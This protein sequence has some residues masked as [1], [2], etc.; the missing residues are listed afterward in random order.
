MQ[1]YDVVIVGAGPA[2]LNCAEKLAGSGKTVLVLEQKDVVGPKVCAGG[3]TKKDIDYLKLP[4]KLVGRR[5]GEFSLHTPNQNIAVELGDSFISTVDRK[6]LGQWQLGKILKLGATVKVSSKVTKICK[7]HVVVNNSE[8]IG[9]RHL[10]GADGSASVVRKHIGLEVSDLGMAIQYI[11]PTKKYRKL[12]AF[13]D[14]DIFHSW[15]CW[16]F[17]HRDFVSIGCGGNPRLISPQKLRKN[18]DKWLK[19]NKINVSAGKFEAFPIN[20]DYRGC[21]FGKIYLVGDAAGLASG[22]TGEGIYQALVSGE[23]VAKM[24]VDKKYVSECVDGLV[25]VN[26]RHSKLLRFFETSGYLRKLEYEL[27]VLGVRNRFVRKLVGCVI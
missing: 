3:L 12:E 1:S 9:F 6:E 20:S 14:S 17:P 18:F 27:L 5:F 11:I 8:K 15:Y 22:Y 4:N 25:A 7:N 24:I 2:G 26:R 10:V 13:L 16:I 21:R 23:E 19:D